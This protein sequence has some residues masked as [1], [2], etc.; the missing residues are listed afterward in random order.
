MNNKKFGVA[1]LIILFLAL[2]YN[3]NAFELTSAELTKEVCPS[4]TALFTAAVSGTG[5]FNINYDGSASSFATV[6][7]QGFYLLNGQR[8]IYIYITPRLNTAQGNYKLNLVVN[9]GETKTLTY[10]INVQNCNKVNIEGD[11]SKEFC[12]CNSESYEYNIINAGNYDETYK[13][14][15]TGNGAQYVTLSEEQFA[16]K[17]KDSKKIIAYYNAPCGSYGTYNFNINVESLTS[18]AAASF[19]SNSKI[20]SCY[21]FNLISEKTFLDMCEHTIQKIPV[22]I[23][24]AADAQ[25]EFNL[26]L[27]GPAWANFEKTSLKLNANSKEDINLLLNPDY[28]VEGSYNVNI[29]ISNKEGKLTKNELIKVNVR[30]CNDVLLDIEKTE[31]TLCNIASK[32]YN[33]MVKNTG[34]VDKE[35]KVSSNL[36]W[37]EIDQ[38]SFLLNA[39]ENKNLKLILTPNKELTGEH[40]L[41]LKVEALDSSK[42]F[43]ED[44]LK[45]NLVSLDLCYI[46]VIEANNIDLKPDTTATVEV[47]VTNNGPEKADYIL[48]ISGTASGFVQLNPGTLEVM[49]G[50]TEV[51]YLYAAP[52][53][54]AKY[55]VYDLEVS[56]RVSGSDVL[57]S[58][59]IQI[60]VSETGTMG[61]EKKEENKIISLW[62]KLTAWLKA[63]IS[64]QQ[65]NLTIE[66]EVK[67]FN[68]T[69]RENITKEVKT[70]EPELNKTAAEEKLALLNEM[71]IISE[72]IKFNFKD[73][74]HEIKIKEIS[75]TSVVLEIN[76]EKQFFILDLNETEKVDL[77]MDGYYD[78]EL[79]LKN[80]I[81]NKPEISV[82]EINEKYEEELTPSSEVLSKDYL[83]SLI[84]LLLA[85]KFYIILGI[86]ILIV[87]ILIISYW[88]EIVDFFEEEDTKK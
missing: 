17:S 13:V 6:V 63:S 42:I 60:K 68:I 72:D 70:Q 22:T 19:A 66:E 53:F 57:E 69:G 75:N 40:E 38:N 61:E 80:V 27:T 4:N 76:S 18:N 3:V 25:N 39:G 23:D 44:F 14:K 77:D 7:P 58:K 41:K 64:V 12:A 32:S 52:P 30:K 55:D 54:N 36:E 71:D 56:A 47:K 5:N 50:K 83:K 84:S 67:E 26:A 81:N 2:I 85:Y 11:I 20:N 15:V 28:K 74:I 45:L 48:G 59:K 78:F 88:K 49:P 8:T 16:L 31:D 62:N 51:V 87:L 21:D 35:F 82:K 9:S 29:K 33:V 73:E 46:P 79:G 43:N 34:E 65:Q 37:S 86:I 1:I 24:N 10:N